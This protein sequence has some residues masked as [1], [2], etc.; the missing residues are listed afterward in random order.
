MFKFDPRKPSGLFCET[1]ENCRNLKGSVA[2][3]SSSTRMEAFNERLRGQNK[4]LKKKLN[5]CHL[6]GNG[7]ENVKKLIGKNTSVAQPRGNV[8]GV[9]RRSDVERELPV[10]A[11]TALGSQRFDPRKPSGLFCET[12]ENC[13]NLKGSVAAA[14]SSTR[15]EAFNERLRGQNK[16]LKKKLNCCHLG[17]NGKENVKVMNDEKI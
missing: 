15:M 10:T 4:K 7:K 17:G 8:H 16:K 5:C 1:V 13:R 12:V 6:G 9:S 2:A 11:I 3:A 14:S